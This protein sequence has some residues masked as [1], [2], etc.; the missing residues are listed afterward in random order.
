MVGGQLAEIAEVLDRLFLFA[1]SPEQSR[2]LPKDKRA[3]KQ[4]TPRD[5]LNGHRNAECDGLGCSQVLIDPV[6][7][8]ESDQRT[9]LV[10]YVKISKIVSA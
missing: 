5:D 10:R 1:L 9:D 4:S 2:R 3:Q 6:I 7:D 8:P